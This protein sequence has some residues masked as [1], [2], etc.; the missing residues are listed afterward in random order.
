MRRQD[1]KPNAYVQT[2]TL[3]SSGHNFIVLALF[4]IKLKKRLIDEAQ[5]RNDVT[6]SGSLNDLSRQFRRQE[7]LENLPDEA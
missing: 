7:V 3:W 2:Y 5:Q 1:F 6:D 4:E